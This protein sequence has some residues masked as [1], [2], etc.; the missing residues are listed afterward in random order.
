[1]E[2]KIKGDMTV[3]SSTR[4]AVRV[5]EGLLHFHHLII[6]HSQLGG[7]LKHRK[8]RFSSLELPT[9]VHEPGY[10]VSKCSKSNAVG[11]EV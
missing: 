10:S 4:Q 8:V 2:T 7:F 11:R 1:M 9:G 3:L 6:H 5:N